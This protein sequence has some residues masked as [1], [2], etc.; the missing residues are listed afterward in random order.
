MRFKKVL[1]IVCGLLL[2]SMVQGQSVLR[3]DSALYQNDFMPKLAVQWVA[4]QNLGHFSTHMLALEH[5]LNDMVNIEYALGVIYDRNVLEVDE[6]YFNEKSGFKSGVKLKFY[7]KGY[8]RFRTFY[9]I[10]AFFNHRNYDRT[11]A[12]ELGCGAGCSFFQEHTYRIGDNSL[13]LRI[14]AGVLFP[15]TSSWYIEM[16]AALGAKHNDLSSVNKPTEAIAAL[17]RTYLEDQRFIDY[18]FNLNIKLA[19]RIK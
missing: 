17:G 14:N 9:A 2:S 13:G 18:S 12:F 19:Y 7:D 15:I 1:I 4:S 11:R 8:R 3:K 5:S 6:I 10:E 16:E